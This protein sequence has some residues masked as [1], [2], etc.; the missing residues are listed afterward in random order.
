MHQDSGEAIPNLF[1]IALLAALSFLFC[2]ERSLD[3]LPPF[4]GSDG[5]I[6]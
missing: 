3:S 5:R 4:V 1:P 6:P 2:E